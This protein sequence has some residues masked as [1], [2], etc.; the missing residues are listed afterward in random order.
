MR[1]ARSEVFALVDCNN[2]YASCERVFQ[3]SLQD[4]PVVVLSNN[5]GCVIARSQEA[6]ALGIPMGAPYFKYQS[7]LERHGVAVFSSNYPLYGDLSRRVMQVLGR[8][9]PRLEI[10]SI[11]ECFL[12]LAGLPNDLTDYGEEIVVTVRRWT[13]IPV[14]I[15]FGPTKALAKLANR[16]AKQNGLPVLDGRDLASDPI[17]AEV[18]V[19]DIWGIAGRWGQRLRALGIEHAQA[20][21]AADPK[22]LRRHFG[23]VMERIVWEL[24]G[25]SCLPLETVVPPR[26]QILT[27]RSFGRK[28]TRFAEL[29]SAVTAFVARA[30][31]KLR[32]QKS[33]AQA[34]T[35][36]VQTSPFETRQAYYS[37][38]Q[39][40]AFA[41]PT[42]DTAALIAA[43]VHGLKQIHRPGLAYQKA[44]VLLLDLTP[45]H[46][47]QAV[48]FP[49]GD[50]RRPPLM[51]VLD[52]I[53]RQFGR[54]T[55]QFG[56]ELLSDRW[57]M[58]QQMKSPSYTT[59]WVA[60]PVVRAF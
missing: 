59:R 16:L 45:A 21:A 53:N 35:V 11:D 39:T 13:G 57:R 52:R 17:L 24:R 5:D 37:N 22:R 46:A 25:I 4:R 15:G 14:S 42:Q 51:S 56:S 58:R 34:L 1:S 40:R 50:D 7:V 41:R 20:L 23:V 48:L 49:S 32:D 2:F 36:F 12:D 54:Q 18:P 10:Y 38:A 31:E 6:K 47:S 55:L 9:T 3:P 8:F 28:L 26:K 19:E 33:C 27:S 60:L 29:R 44:G 43:A 30:G